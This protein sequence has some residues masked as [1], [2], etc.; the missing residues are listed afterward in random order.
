M[1]P[2]RGSRWQSQGS[3]VLGGAWC[4]EEDKIDISIFSRHFTPTAHQSKILL[5][6]RKTLLSKRSTSSPSSKF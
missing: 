5:A 4:G 2:K 3:P 6:Q 1:A